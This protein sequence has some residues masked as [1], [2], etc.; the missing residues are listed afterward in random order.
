MS[1]SRKPKKKK[2]DNGRRTHEWVWNTF[3][4]FCPSVLHLHLRK[5]HSVNKIFSWCFLSMYSVSLTRHRPL[6]HT[7]TVALEKSSSFNPQLFTLLQLENHIQFAM[8]IPC[9]WGKRWIL[10]FVLA[11]ARY[12]WVQDR[13]LEITRLTTE[14]QLRQQHLEQ[15][16]HWNTGCVS[17]IVKTSKCWCPCS[18]T[19][20]TESLV[21]SKMEKL[22][23]PIVGW[24]LFSNRCQ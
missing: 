21:F 20:H 4:E 10:S 19:G 13:L 14:V 15:R 1:F 2:K 22:N 23:I 5:Y 12:H 8:L 9:S 7:W 24:I 17:K 6:M 3:K 18:K 16:K 11:K